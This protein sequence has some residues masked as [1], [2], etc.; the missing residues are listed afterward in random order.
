VTGQG[1]GTAFRDVELLAEALADGLDGRRPL[2][3]ALADRWRRRDEA[4]MPG[5]QYTYQRAR[6]EPPTAEAQRLLAALQG[7]QPEI[8]R[9]VGLS[10]GTT[11]FADFF[12]PESQGRIIG[13]AASRAA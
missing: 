11:S 12:S 8:D 3:D 6:L 10:A 4:V 5:Y 2:E 7:N 1:I 9:F 13:R